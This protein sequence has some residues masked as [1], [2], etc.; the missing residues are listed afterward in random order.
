MYLLFL[1]ISTGEILVIF[2]AFLLLFGPS[3]IPGLA[4]KLGRF[5]Y[6]IRHIRTDVEQKIWQEGQ[7]LNEYVT[8][9]RSGQATSAPDKIPGEIAEG[10]VINKKND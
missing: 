8:Q 3:S 9:K 6:E 10:E 7:R 4:Q 1:D 2:I 5:L